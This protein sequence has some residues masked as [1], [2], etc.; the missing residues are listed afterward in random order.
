MYVSSYV[1]QCVL[2]LRKPLCCSYNKRNKITTNEINIFVHHLPTPKFMQHLSRIIVNI[3]V[4]LVA[5]KYAT[6]L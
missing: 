5:L 6:Y 4:Y 2:W 3:A 1:I